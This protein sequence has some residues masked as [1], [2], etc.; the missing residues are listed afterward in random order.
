MSVLF[1]TLD[2][3]TLAA[4]KP[5]IWLRASHGPFI[6]LWR[7]AHVSPLLCAYGFATVDHAFARLARLLLSAPQGELKRAVASALASERMHAHACG[8]VSTA[9]Y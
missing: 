4:A 8:L 9:C 5:L 7:N 2:P 3:R 6:D 1:R